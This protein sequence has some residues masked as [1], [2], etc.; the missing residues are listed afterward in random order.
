MY[1]ELLRILETTIEML[2]VVVVIIFSK[3]AFSSCPAHAQDRERRGQKSL[4]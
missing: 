4:F 1:A 2:N 3:E